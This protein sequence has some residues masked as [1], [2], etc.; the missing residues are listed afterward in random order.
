MTLFVDT[1]KPAESNCRTL[2]VFNIYEDNT[3]RVINGA[4]I[5]PAPVIEEIEN[6]YWAYP[7]SATKYCAMV[8]V[9]PSTIEGEYLISM[10]EFKQIQ[11]Y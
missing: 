6:S 2:I 9:E 5:L 11:E 8:K 10:D 3:C 7:F 1:R 4:G